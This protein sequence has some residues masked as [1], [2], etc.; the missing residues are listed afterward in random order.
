MKKYLLFIVAYFI[1]FSV[2]A[3]AP[4]APGNLRIIDY[5][6]SLGIDDPHPRF[7]WI[8]NDADRGER[9]TAY[10]VMVS[11]S[12]AGLYKKSTSLWNS[13]KIISS[14]Q[15]GIMYDGKALSSTTKY[16]WKVRTWDKDGSVSPWSPAKSFVTAFLHTNDWDKTAMWIRHPEAVSKEI[17]PLPMFRKKFLVSKPVKQAWLYITGL[18]H[19]VASINGAKIGD[20]EI[21][22]AWTDYD[23]TVSYI[24][25][26]VAAQIKQGDNVLGVMLGPGWF[27]YKGMRDFGPMKMLAQLHIDY[28]DGSSVNITSDTSWKVKNSPY[29]FVSVHGSENYDARLEVAGWNMPLLNDA[30]WQNAKTVAA[31]SG[32]LTSQSSPPVKAQQTLTPKTITTSA[33]NTHVFDFG[34]NMNGQFEVKVSGPAGSIIKIKSG[35]S[36]SPEG[37]AVSNKNTIGIQYTLKGI[38]IETCRLT[39]STIGFR[40][41]EVENVSLDSLQTVMP[42]IRSVQSFFTYTASHNSGSFTTSDDRYNKIYDLALNTLRSNLVSIHT[43]GPLYEKLGWQEVAWTLLPSSAYQ[44]DLQN[45]FTKITRDICEA[46]RS[47]GLSPNIAPNYWA[48]PSTPPGNAFDDAPAWGASMF[49]VPWQLFFIYGDTQVLK[50]S[51]D[52]MKAYLAYLKTKETATEVINYGLGDWMAPGG[53][54]I[55]NV[56]GAVYVMD[57][58]VMRDVARVLN[59]TADETFYAAE[60]ERVRKAY[61]KAYYTLDSKTYRPVSQA[62]LALPVAFGIVPEGDEKD[63]I[64]ALLKDIENPQ[65]IGIKGSYGEKDEF[66]PVLPYHVSTGDIGTTF[67]WRALGDAGQADLV[68]TMIMQ[69]DAPGYMSMINKGYT[70]IPENW[71][72]PKARSHNHDMYAGIFE[73]LYRSL[74]GISNTKPGYEEIKIKPSLPHGLNSVAASYECVRGKISSSWTVKEK[75]F[76]FKIDIP[77]NTTAVVYVPATAKNTIKESGK[78]VADVRTIKFLRMEDGYAVF[79]VGSGSY[80]FDSVIN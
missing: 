5:F 51:Y 54:S 35:E 77:V 29:T 61:N 36:L 52:K 55:A 42:C 78:P 9:Q 8:L 39:F 58:R 48:T 40:Y 28:T 4:G 60:Y 79:A 33:A 17:N 59:N 66:G 67:L 47:G 32:K 70:T 65:V 26:D 37:H 43:D 13:G 31:P 71:N 30:D 7:G 22:P 34:Q 14:Q 25:F 12:E 62:N 53:S 56:E 45:L 69:P 19:F 64:K 49:M 72:L 38:N 20:H 15:Y 80:V 11:A 16:W 46:Q 23:K 73:W 27:V 6:S 75:R 24:T 44:H 10:Q 63:V 21:D 41:V 50:D 57:T 2:C 68:Q 3:T 18:G 74:A 1:S 76:H